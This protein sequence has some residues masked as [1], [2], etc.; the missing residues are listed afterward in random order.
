MSNNEDREK[1]EDKKKKERK[2]I[3]TGEEGK[4]KTTTLSTRR[5][6]CNGEEGQ[7]RHNYLTATYGHGH[8]L[9]FLF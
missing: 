7:A 1:S 9:S 4:K 8:P 6:G 2:R 3:R 5:W